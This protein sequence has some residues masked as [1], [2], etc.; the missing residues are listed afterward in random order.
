M[1]LAFIGTYF[2]LILF[3]FAWAFGPGAVFFAVLAS[4]LALG[5]MYAF[6]RPGEPSAH[7]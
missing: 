5:A 1:P 2:V 4:G 6:T 3:V 7:A